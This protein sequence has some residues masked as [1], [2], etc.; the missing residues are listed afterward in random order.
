MCFKPNVY[1]GSAIYSELSDMGLTIG[2]SQV[3]AQHCKRR[4]NGIVVVRHTREN[5]EVLVQGILN[6]EF[7]LALVSSCNP[8]VS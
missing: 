1:G 8:E 6:H 7:Y 2:E 5:T 3:I 4:K